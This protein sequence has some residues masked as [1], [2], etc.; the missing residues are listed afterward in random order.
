MPSFLMKAFHE[1]PCFSLKCSQL[2]QLLCLFIPF[3]EIPFTTS[4]DA[5]MQ[6]S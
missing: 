6:L 1:Q 4:S 5:E 2:M 3:D